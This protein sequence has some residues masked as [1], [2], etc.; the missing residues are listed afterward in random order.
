[1]DLDNNIFPQQPIHPIDQSDIDTNNHRPFEPDITQCERCLDWY[2]DESIVKISKIN[3]HQL[4]NVC[5]NCCIFEI[6][7]EI[8]N[9]LGIKIKPIQL[10]CPLSDGIYPN[11]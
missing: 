3:T 7:E 9:T 6:E 4:E 1:M 2:Y 11:H 8:I 10:L 5:I